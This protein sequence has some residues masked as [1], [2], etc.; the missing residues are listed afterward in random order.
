MSDKPEFTL[1]GH[2]AGVLG[3][4]MDHHWIVTASRDTTLRVWHRNTGELANI[5]RGHNASVN[6]C[7]I[8]EGRIASAAADGSVHIW[9]PS[10]GET[11]QELTGI[12]NGVATVFLSHDVC[13][14]GSSDKAVRIWQWR[15][16]QCICQF[17][18]HHQLVRT[19]TYDPRKYLLVTGGWDRM[20]RIWHLASLLDPAQPF[21]NQS[22]PHLLLENGMHHGRIFHVSMDATRVLAACEDKSVWITDYMNP[23]LCAPHLYY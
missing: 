8:N 11:L 4:C 14:T 3:V 2:E 23:D 13:F 5:Y 10:T 6:T 18:A 9:D 12:S 16:G 17:Q 7:H 19:L 22:A 1:R 15:T 20:T 21:Y